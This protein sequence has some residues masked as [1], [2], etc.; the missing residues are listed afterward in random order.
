MTGLM[1]GV[2][3]RTAFSLSF[4]LSGCLAAG[5]F[6]R[7]LVCVCLWA[8]LWPAAGHHRAS[9][10][11]CVI[12]ELELSTWRD[13]LTFQVGSLRRKLNRGALLCTVGPDGSVL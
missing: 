2:R 3:T 8:E 10:P 6:V 12:A 9:V 5:L 1:T 7:L 11:S 13:L 4:C